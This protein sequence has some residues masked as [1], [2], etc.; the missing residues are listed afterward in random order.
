MV[1]RRVK[2]QSTEL[3]DGRSIEVT[4]STYVVKEELKMLGFKWQGQSLWI[5]P[6]TRLELNQAIIAL[7][8]AGTDVEV[9]NGAMAGRVFKLTSSMMEGSC[10]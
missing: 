3:E 7:L 6:F 1:R 4:G 8:E 10:P 9:L 5:L 2:L